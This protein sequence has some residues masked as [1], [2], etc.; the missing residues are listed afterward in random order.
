M[1]YNL[2]YANESNTTFSAKYFV[3]AIEVVNV[4]KM[5]EMIQSILSN[6]PYD[7]FSSD[8]LRIKRA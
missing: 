8:E 7:N 4:T 5:M 3:K 1:F 2:Q 6:I